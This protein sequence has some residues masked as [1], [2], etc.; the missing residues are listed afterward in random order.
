MRRSPI[1]Q[2]LELQSIALFNKASAEDLS[3]VAAFVAERDV[4]KGTV[5]FREGEPGDAL[6]LIRSGEVELSKQKTVV[7]RLMP[8][9]AFGVVAVLDRLPRELT[10]VATQACSLLV[11]RQS[12]LFQLLADRPLLMHSVFRALTSS[13]RDQ[14]DRV[15]LG[16]HKES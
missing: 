5:V 6:Y 13:I 15:S 12:D 7:A 2:I 3:E 4:S 8:G 9:E 14:L 16:K 11:L 10:A 1:E